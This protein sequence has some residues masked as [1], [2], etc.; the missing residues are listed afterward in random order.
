MLISKQLL[1]ESTVKSYQYCFFLINLHHMEI[2]LYTLYFIE[3][4]FATFKIRKDCKLNICKFIH[5]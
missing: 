3:A 2:T 1:I 5:D 4:I